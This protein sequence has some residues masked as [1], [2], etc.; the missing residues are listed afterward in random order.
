MHTVTVF[1]D[2]QRDAEMALVHTHGGAGEFLLRIFL[3]YRVEARLGSSD[4]YTASAASYAFSIHD[5]SRREIVAFHRAPDGIGTVRT[6]HAHLSAAAPIVLP[7]RPGSP[8][9]QTKAHLGRLHLPTGL[10]AVEDVVEL[11]IRDFAAVPLRPDWR[12]VLDHN[13]QTAGADA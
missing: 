4:R 7:Q 10:I 3:T 8:L 2:R 5:R 6:P 1:A 11:L 9:A 12:E 13:R